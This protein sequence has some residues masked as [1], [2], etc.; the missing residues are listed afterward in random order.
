LRAPGIA[1]FDSYPLTNAWVAQ[2]FNFPKGNF[3]STPNDS[4][5]LQGLTVQALHH[6]SAANQP[7]WVFVEAGADNLGFGGQN[8]NFPGAVSS[9]S[10][11]LTNVSGWSKFTA[12]WLGLTVSGAG[13]PANT[14]ITQIIDSTHALMSHVATSTSANET[15]TITG[16]VNNSDCVATSNICVAQGNEYRATPVE[17]NAE[18]WMSIIN[19]ANGIEYFCH[20]LA[21]YAFC[22]G[23]SAGGPAAQAVQ[24][25]LTYINKTILSFAPVLNAATTGICSMDNND[26]AGGLTTSSTC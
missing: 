11:T 10:G 19:G 2:A 3:L 22:L 14:T 26:Y 13:I 18:V 17:V 5:W 9:G 20:D 15:I 16:G 6:F 1:S 24:A 8:N 7:L 23:D 12:T 25:N 21:S 4:L